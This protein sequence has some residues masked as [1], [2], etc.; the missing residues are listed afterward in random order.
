MLSNSRVRSLRPWG[1]LLPALLVV[2]QFACVENGTLTPIGIGTTP[3]VSSTVTPP[4]GTMA[5]TPP[6]SSMG[7]AMGGF[8]LRDQKLIRQGSFVNRV[9]TVKGVAGIYENFA[10]PN[11]RWTLVFSDFSTDGVP[12]LRIYVAEDAALTNAIEVSKLTNTGNFSVELP[13]TYN[14]DQHKM[15]LIWCKPFSVLF[16]SATLN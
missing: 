1:I 4:A 15:V 11:A 10:Q 8:D 2:G 7:S 16:G 12:D 9:H 5:T 3:P 6:G 14:P 13:A